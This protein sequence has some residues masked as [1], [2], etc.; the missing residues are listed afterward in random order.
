ML[1]MQTGL[2]LLK[3]RI[4]LSFVSLL[5]N[6]VLRISISPNKKKHLKHYLFEDLDDNKNKKEKKEY[7]MVFFLLA[8]IYFT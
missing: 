4:Y 7:S 8:S 5:I 1:S 3:K 6:E 2:F